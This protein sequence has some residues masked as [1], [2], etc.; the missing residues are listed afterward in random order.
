MRTSVRG[1]AVALALW[2]FAGCGIVRA[3]VTEDEPRCAEFL[4]TPIPPADVNTSTDA[5][6]VAE[7]L[8]YGPAGD[9]TRADPVA[10]RACA[11]RERD[12]KADGPFEGAAILSM[13]YA[14]GT[15]V[16]KNIPLAKRFVCE[17]GGAPA[18]ISGR[19]D[20]LDGAPEVPSGNVRF[21]VCD[22]VTS[23]YMAGFC[24]QHEAK[25]QTHQREG[26]L[27]A[28]MKSW[29]P[30]QRTAYAQLRKTADAYF[31][32][33][34][35]E[36]VDMSGTLRG[37]MAEGAR[38]SLED[39]FV[40]FLQ[41]CEKGELPGGTA[42]DYKKADAELNAAYVHVMKSL[43]PDENGFTAQGTVKA[44]GVRRTE[45]AWIKY[46]DAWV[47]FGKVKYPTVS[48][49]AWRKALTDERTENLRELTFENS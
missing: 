21:D 5:K 24:A 2:G 4:K 42:A 10:A 46:R 35:N 49:D 19:L 47:E 37:A 8:Y 22:D 12:A 14:N 33:S 48:A 20:H 17:A 34:V 30:E 25:I 36:E 1:W 3:D 31:E 27:A 11:W 15:G 7:N 39:G 38:Q 32:T 40:S 29:T 28:L 26:T 45:V 16:K 43:K 13:L 9:F 6:C 44:E 18:E 41:K 23:G